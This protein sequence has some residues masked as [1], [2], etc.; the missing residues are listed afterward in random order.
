MG[1]PFLK[2]SKAQ[3]ARG[4]AQWNR[5]RDERKDLQA[6]GRRIE[7]LRELAGSG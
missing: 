3:I 4:A 2:T 5:T 1:L 7:R 6:E